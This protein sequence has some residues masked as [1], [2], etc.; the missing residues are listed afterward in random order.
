MPQEIGKWRFC[1]RE[2]RG[3]STFLKGDLEFG[4]EDVALEMP[5]GQPKGDFE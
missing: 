3:R 2:D 5:A 1:T 4:F